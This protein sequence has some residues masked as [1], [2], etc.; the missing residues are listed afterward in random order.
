[1]AVKALI[2]L[3]VL[4]EMLAI[5]YVLGALIALLFLVPIAAYERRR[6]KA[7]PEERRRMD[8]EDEEDLQVW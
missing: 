6:Y 2:P 8:A 5:P 3:G 4:C 7:T 1:M